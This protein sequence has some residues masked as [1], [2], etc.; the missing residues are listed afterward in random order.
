MTFILSSMGIGSIISLLYLIIVFAI[1]YSTIEKYGY[2][3]NIFIYAFLR[4]IV[5]FIF[6][7]N[8]SFSILLIFIL[9]LI[10]GAIV[11]LVAKIIRDGFEYD[12]IVLYIIA[13]TVIETIVLFILKAFINLFI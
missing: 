2:I 4:T 1:I 11:M 3:T 13:I 8:K 6:M 9:Y 5:P 12:T 7:E 10:S